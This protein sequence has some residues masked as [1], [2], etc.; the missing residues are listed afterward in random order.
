VK[1][2]IVLSALLVLLG[3]F[4]L[5]DITETS[6]SIPDNGILHNMESKAT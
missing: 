5:S 4:V 3:G 2:L 1:R 6:A